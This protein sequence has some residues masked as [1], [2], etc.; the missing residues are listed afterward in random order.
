[1]R[2]VEDSL[3]TLRKTGE[4]RGAQGARLVAERQVLD[5]SELRYKGGV[6]SYLEVLDSQRSLFD[7]EIDDLAS[8]T[9]HARSL[10]RLYKALGGGWPA[11]HPPATD[12]QSPPGEG[13]APAEPVAARGAH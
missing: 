5:L 10:I 4:Q 3:I 6:S 2:E 13:T 9:E 1:M 12:G 11:D 7:A 8:A